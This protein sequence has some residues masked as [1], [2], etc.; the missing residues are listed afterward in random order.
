M[1]EG[2]KSMTTAQ[3]AEEVLSSLREEMEKDGVVTSYEKANYEAL[4][5]AIGA[6]S[7]EALL[8]AETFPKVTEV[9]GNHA[10]AAG[11]AESALE[12]YNQKIKDGTFDF[13]AWK[14]K[15]GQ[16]PSINEETKRSFDD[17]KTGGFDPIE[18]ALQ[19]IG[20]AAAAD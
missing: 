12:D 1:A 15:W 20:Y 4:G 11:D 3:M 9:I 2:Y 5:L 13:D 14:E 17:L 8:Y 18:E 6:T 16:A 10:I 19:G 7:E